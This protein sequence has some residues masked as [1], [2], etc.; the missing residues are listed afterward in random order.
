M[1][2]LVL[3]VGNSLL[4]DE[5]AGVHA[6]RHLEG[7]CRTR[8]D[9]ELVDAGTL[10]FTL[11]GTID[12]CGALIV[13][14]AAEL[15]EAPGTVRLFEHEA[16][17]RFLA[18]NRKLSVHEVSLLDL[19]VMARLAGR[20]PERRALI[21]IQPRDIDWGERPSAPVAAAL[22]AAGDIALSLI[23]RWSAHEAQ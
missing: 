16:M 1:K 10:S 23:D 8:D 6:V 14:D 4:T 15:K 11:A 9:V 5:G 20:L 19:L 13:I 22:P 7:R 3:G 2:T 18:H 12:D 17:D 21:G